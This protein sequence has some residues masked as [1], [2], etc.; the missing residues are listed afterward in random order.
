M[1]WLKKFRQKGILFAN[2]FDCTFEAAQLPVSHFAE[3]VAFD[4]Y[5]LKAAQ[6]G[7]TP[8][9][10]TRKRKNEAWV[11]VK[12]FLKMG[13]LTCYYAARLTGNHILKKVYPI[14]PREIGPGYVVGE[15]K[16]V[17]MLPGKYTFNR[18]KKLKAFIYGNPKGLLQK[19]L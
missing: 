1:H 8:I 11:D 10:L 3:P 19:K 15:K 17:T 7:R 16:I 6:A 14:T 5:L 2:Q 9:S 18:N 13:I 4:S 12:E